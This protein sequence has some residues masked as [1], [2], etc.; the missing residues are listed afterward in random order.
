MVWSSIAFDSLRCEKDEDGPLSTPA[1]NITYIT[2]LMQGLKI[3][4]HI[5]PWTRKMT[6]IVC[7]CPMGPH[8]PFSK[9]RKVIGVNLFPSFI[10]LSPGKRSNNKTTHVQ[11]LQRHSPAN[12]IS[13]PC[14]CHSYL[15][16]SH[17]VYIADMSGCLIPSK[18]V[19][20]TSMLEDSALWLARIGC[21]GKTCC[22]IK[23][24]PN[25][26]GSNDRAQKTTFESQG[27][28]SVKPFTGL[29]NLPA[30]TL[31]WSIPNLGN[32]RKPL[33]FEP[34][35]KRIGKIIEIVT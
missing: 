13:L 14:L 20:I 3:W 30:P 7:C 9:F 23:P 8:I 34:N 1:T 11:Y 21:A 19:L 31:V 10:R 12:V 2:C 28:L 4:Q 16:W 22:P 26:D 25:H 15:W 35:I 32:L 29:E 33:W 17:T 5:C 24:H 6:K 27:K 18:H